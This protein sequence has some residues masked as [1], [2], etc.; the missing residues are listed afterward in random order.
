MRTAYLLQEH[1]DRCYYHRAK[2]FFLKGQI[3]GLLSLMHTAKEDVE[4][5]ELLM[6]GILGVPNIK[7]NEID[8][9]ALDLIWGMHP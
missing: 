5:V 2:S 8:R 6:V 9:D 1:N 4:F 3:F 7:M